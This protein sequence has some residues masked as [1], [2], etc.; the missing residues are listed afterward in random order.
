MLSSAAADA[1][2]QENLARVFEQR[3]SLKVHSDG[4]RVGP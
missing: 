3:F 4:W 1:I 2:A